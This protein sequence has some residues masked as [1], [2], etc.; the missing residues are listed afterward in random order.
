MISTRKRLLAYFN[1]ADTEDTTKKKH[2]LASIHFDLYGKNP[3]YWYEEG[4][5]WFTPGEELCS[6]LLDTPDIYHS[7]PALMLPDSH[8]C[9]V[10]CDGELEEHDMLPSKFVDGAEVAYCR[11]WEH[12][13]FT[14]KYTGRGVSCSETGYYPIVEKG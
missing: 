14:N 12:R 6:T 3:R 1:P 5:R 13:W 7:A 10:I 9:C 11:G 2:R 8:D 4:G